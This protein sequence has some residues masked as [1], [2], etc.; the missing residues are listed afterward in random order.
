MKAASMQYEGLAGPV[1]AVMAVRWR[2]CGTMD[3]APR[4]HARSRSD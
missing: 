3:L 1:S 2:P 4:G